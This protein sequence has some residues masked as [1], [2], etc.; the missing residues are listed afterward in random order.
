MVIG[1]AAFGAAHA[2]EA[3]AWRSAFAPG[4]PVGP[5]FLNSGRAVAFTAA[6]LFVAA[7]ASSALARRGRQPPRAVLQTGLMQAA[8][9]V[10]A[11]TAVLAAVG[12]G[13]IFPIALAAGGLVA[14]LAC[15][16]GAFLGSM[17]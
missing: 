2:V 3:A 7:A 14:V 4:S 11:M 8:G 15:V 16:A 5:W 9:A 12:F 13:T 1:A 10:L 17:V 6:C